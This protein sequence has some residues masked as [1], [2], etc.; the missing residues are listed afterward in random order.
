MA[1][2]RLCTVRMR[3]SM[4]RNRA[5]ADT[6]PRTLSTR[7]P[8]ETSR[9]SAIEGRRPKTQNPRPKHTSP[10][11]THPA[12]KPPPYI[13]H[14]H[15]LPS[16]Q[17]RMFPSGPNRLAQW[18]RVRLPLQRTRGNDNPLHGRP[19]YRKTFTTILD[20]EY[21]SSTHLRMAE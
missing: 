2:E 12:T 9:G 19:R 18:S 8:W 21:R 4:H 6:Q 17:A 3:V 15:K 1:T 7:P 10:A 20:L 14:P 13:R 16:Q 11:P 5:Q